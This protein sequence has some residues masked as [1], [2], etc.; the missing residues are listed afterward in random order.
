MAL[1]DTLTAVATSFSPADRRLAIEAK[2]VPVHRCT[3]FLWCGDEPSS[4]MFMAVEADYPFDP[5]CGLACFMSQTQ[6]W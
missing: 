3:M 5:D 2:D 6:E 4:N 1:V